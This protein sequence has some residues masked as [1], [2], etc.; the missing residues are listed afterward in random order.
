MQ[1]L[2]GDIGGVEKCNV[3]IEVEGVDDACDMARAQVKSRHEQE[4]RGPGGGG[5]REEN[6]NK[7]VGSSTSENV[8]DIMA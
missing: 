3:V 5:G 7:Q 1:L 8:G 6:V 4:V 2:L